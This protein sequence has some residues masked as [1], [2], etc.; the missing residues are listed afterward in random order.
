MLPII[1]PEPAAPEP[2][3]PEPA[4]PEPE[5]PKPAAKKNVVL[6]L[7]VEEGQRVPD[8]DDPGV[9]KHLIAHS[10]LFSSTEYRLFLPIFISYSSTIRLQLTCLLLVYREKSRLILIVA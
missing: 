9:S 8:S 1:A 5:A 2:A 7:E 10:S 3:A 6:S 4:A